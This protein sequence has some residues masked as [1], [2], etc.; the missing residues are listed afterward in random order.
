VSICTGQT[1]TLTASGASTYTWNPGSITGSSFTVAPASNST[2]SV[3]G[4]NGTCSSV[5]TASVDVGS[6]ISVSIN[7]ATLCAG[8]TVTLTASSSA[9]SFTWNT[10]AN[11]TSITASPTVSTVYTV[12]ASSG[13][14]NGVG[15]A[16]V[17]VNNLPS[18]FIDGSDI[19]MGQTVTLT[20]SGASTYTWNPTGANSATLTDSPATT[21]TYTLFGE[22]S[23]CIGLA[24]YSVTVK[25]NPTLTVNSPTICGGSTSLTASGASNYLWSPGSLT[26]ASIVVSPTTTTT[27]TVLGDSL[28]CFSTI[29]TTVTVNSAPALIISSDVNAGCPGA[30]VNFTSATTGFSGLTFD[31]GDGS[32]QTPSVTTHCYTSG[33]TFTVYA[34]G[35]HTSGCSINSANTLTI[36][37]TPPPVPVFSTSGAPFYPNTSVNFVNTTSGVNF[38]NW[39]FGDGTAGTNTLTSPSH[40]YSSTGNYCIKL[41]ATDSITGCKD[42]VT[43]CIDILLPVSINIPNVFTPN[44]DG[45]NEVFKVT[46]VG[47]RAVNCAIFDR[48]GLKMYEWDG[49]GGG[50][51]GKTKSGMAVPTGTYFYIVTY[52]DITDKTETVKGFL[53]LYKD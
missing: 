8:Q 4:A 13:A 32:V 25:P 30:C 43:N 17:T 22:A 47:L 26:G 33:G 46:G 10:G 23:G 12:N 53:M 28:G 15:T 5:A 51:D 35:T 6:A 29:T 20:G 27:Y 31:F 39:D 24:T 50:W 2:Y 49:T 36:N 3:I 41:V 7:N 16:T 1:A 44:D 34:S 52:T 40:A 21:T 48:W 14:C 11:T 38:Y 37:V 45:V 19:C 42:S 9:S 18:I